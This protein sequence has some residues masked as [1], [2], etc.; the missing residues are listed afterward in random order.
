MTEVGGPATEDDERWKQ[1]AEDLRHH[2][3]AAMREA[4]GKWLQSIALILG[5][6]S[7]AAFIKGTDSLSDVDEGL[8]YTL[9]CLVLAAALATGAA[10]ALAALASQ[11]SPKIFDVLTGPTLKAH[12][13]TSYHTVARQLLWSR[14]LTVLAALLIASGVALTWFN[15]IPGEQASTV[16]ILI[17]GEDG[18]ITCSPVKDGTLGVD[19]SARA[20]LAHSATV[21]LVSSCP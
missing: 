3:L 10:T 5:A 8:A 20:A 19:A 12:V 1:E 21:Q 17:V 4:A 11:G 7:V 9:T 13:E 15:S 18:T 14:L 6:F 16:N 2:G